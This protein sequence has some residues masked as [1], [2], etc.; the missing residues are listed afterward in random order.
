MNKQERQRDNKLNTIKNNSL[1]KKQNRHISQNNGK[2]NKNVAV[3]GF[4]LL[5][6]RMTSTFN[7]K[8]H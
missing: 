5:K 8:T 2:F 3:T 6:Y 1:P 7:L 4:R